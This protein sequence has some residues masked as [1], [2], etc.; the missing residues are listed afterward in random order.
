MNEQLIQE[1]ERLQKIFK[2][3]NIN[4]TII[5]FSIKR[6]KSRDISCVFLKFKEKYKTYRDSNNKKVNK[7]ISIS[8][9]KNQYLTSNNIEI[10]CPLA[11]GTII[12]ENDKWNTYQKIKNILINEYWI[13]LQ[14]LDMI[15]NRHVKY[16]GNDN[17]MAQSLYDTY[18][19]NY[20]AFPEQVS[21][22]TLEEH[23]NNFNKLIEKKLINTQPLEVKGTYENTDVE[24]NFSLRIFG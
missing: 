15:F 21:S 14:E 18:N 16:F 17:K 12:D 5:K 13:F 1:K 2:E 20:H 19:A 9:A 3:N 23:I 8:I 7:W 6:Y 24:P 10:Y 11:G 4:E 22:Y